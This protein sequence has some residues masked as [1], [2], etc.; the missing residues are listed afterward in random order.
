[1]HAERLAARHICL[2]STCLPQTWGIAGRAACPPGK[3]IT[4]LGA[5]VRAG[6]AGPRQGVGAECS[7]QCDVCVI[8]ARSEIAPH[9]QSRQE[10]PGSISFTACSSAGAVSRRVH[11]C[12]VND[13]E[14]AARQRGRCSG[15]ARITCGRTPWVDSDD[16]CGSLSPL[17]TW[18][19]NFQERL[20][21]PSHLFI[22]KT[23][24]TS[25]QRA[26]CIYTR[27]LANFTDPSVEIPRGAPVTTL[28]TAIQ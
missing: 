16:P 8:A 21:L 4:P 28:F 7:V 15:G 13:P 3:E 2:T 26:Q 5:L 9:R 25:P 6:T 11:D 1:M 17:S 19:N 14:A 18:A 24:T 20:S 23:Y 27:P 12:R 10:R 22:V